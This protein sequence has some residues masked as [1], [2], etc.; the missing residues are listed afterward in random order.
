MGLIDVLIAMTIL[1]VAIMS[2]LSLVGSS[3]R[4]ASVNRESTLAVQ[5]AR[6]VMEEL[7]AAP[8]E[9]VFAMYNA[10]TDDDPAGLGTAP[11]SAFAVEGLPPRPDDVDGLVGEVWMPMVGAALR[12]DVVDD[13]LGTPMDLD[14]DGVMDGLDHAANFRVLPVLVRLRWRGSTGDGQY[15]IST[16]LRGER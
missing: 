12:E 2:L 16:L 9:E 8:F 3:L 11:G 6:R 4:L 10:A 5:A 14:K 13:A 7:S 1:T 15:E